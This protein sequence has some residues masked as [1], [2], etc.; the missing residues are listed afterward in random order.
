MMLSKQNAEK[1][2]ADYIEIL[3]KQMKKVRKNFQ[4]MDLDRVEL[5]DD[6]KNKIEDIET[7]VRNTIKKMNNITFE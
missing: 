3:E 4:E 2:R 1:I 6:I 5:K 7:T